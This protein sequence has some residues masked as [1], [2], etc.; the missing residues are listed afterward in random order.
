MKVSEIL[1]SRNVLIGSPEPDSPALIRALIEVIAKGKEMDVETVVRDVMARERSGATCIPQGDRAVAIPH[2]T[3]TACKQLVLAAAVPSRGIQWTGT[4]ASADIVFL[5]LGPREAY[6]L[7]LKVLSRIARLCEGDG[8]LSALVSTRSP[9]DFMACIAAAEEGMGAITPVE[10]MPRFCV[11]GAG[12]GGL[13]MAGHLSLLG[14]A[15]NLYNRTF[16]RIA[17]IQ[18]R[19]GVE[20]HGSLEGFARLGTV[21]ND[22]AAALEKVDVAMVVVPATAH[23]DIARTLGP[24]LKDGQIVVLNPGRTGGALEFTRVLREVSPSARPYIAESQTLL[25]ATR[26]TNPGEVHIHGIKNSVPL[27]AFPAYLTADILTV[28]NKVLPQFVPGDNVLKTSLDNIGAIF[29]PAI[30]IL[31]AGRIEET[32]GD[33]QYYIEG[34]TPSIA[35]VLEQL[36]RERVAVAAALG[37]HVNTAREWLYLAYD[38]AGRTLLDAIRAN[39]NYAGIKA[40][41]TVQHRY[42]SE[43]V[44]ASLVPIASLG[45]MFGTPTPTIRSIIQMASVMHGVDYWAQGRTVEKL[46]IKGLSVKEIRFLV[47]GAMRQEA[48]R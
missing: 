45:E 22:P 42:I 3:T 41:V 40:P 2:A 12:N 30:T 34:V 31:N 23:A 7:Y 4:T 28:L 38:V 29:H 35:A 21:T 16:E 13:A 5:L 17:P 6:S 47:V 43:D 32:H 18:A 25:Y 8:F 14:C 26:I 48:R 15:V 27:A 1:S 44:P 46:G 20:V 10:E 11:I 39:P 33:F 37:I 9:E 36:D 19:G 24:H